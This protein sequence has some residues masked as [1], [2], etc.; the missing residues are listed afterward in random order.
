MNTGATPS[1]DPE[2]ALE[3]DELPLAGPEEGGDLPDT[4]GP[5]YNLIAVSLIVAVLSIVALRKL[6][7]KK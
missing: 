1:P 5:W 7:T 2:I 4:A 3:E 6:K